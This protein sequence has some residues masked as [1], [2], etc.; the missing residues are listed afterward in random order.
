M[1][2]RYKK[3]YTCTP[4]AFHANDGFFIRD[5]GLL[6][7]GIRSMG[8]ESKCIM[9]LP[10]YEDDQKE[11]LIR[12]SMTNLKS[13][14]WWKSLGID[15]LILYSWGMPKYNAIAR[16]IHKAGIRLVIHMDTSG[17]FDKLLPEQYT[18]LKAMLKWCTST[19]QN[20]FRA[21]HL[22]YADVI[23]M[24]APVAKAISNKLFFDSS[25]AE[26][27]VPMPC[28]VAPECQYDGQKKK[29]LILAVGRW[30]D[31]LQKRPHI[32]MQTL[33]NF[34]AKG[35]CQAETYIYGT[36]TD[37]LTTWHQSLSPAVREKIS[38]KGYTPNHLLRE[39]YQQAK[40]IL[41]PSSYESSHI[42]SAEGLCC[43]CSIVVPTRPAPLRDV[44]WYTTKNS[45]TVSAEDTPESLA[46]ALHAELHEWESGN[47]NPHEI[48]NTW[49]EHF[50][51]DKVLPL[52]FP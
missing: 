23:T 2:P 24:G 1:N 16:A 5:T 25:V 19:V 45:G 31:I 22:S 32:L 41:C 33:E 47:R 10:Y 39:A 42:V 35:N 26:K 20:Y 13:V 36:L 37:E 29:E 14:E 49:S 18:P 44:M 30:D 48:A 17:N 51:T 15:G 3:I 28:P 8:I 52:M 34:Y 4:V 9:P 21:K 6:A 46:E 40:I 7:A 43:G 38:L 27:N 50:H 12:T 11:H